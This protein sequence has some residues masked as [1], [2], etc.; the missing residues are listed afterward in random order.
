MSFR[1]RLTLGLVAGAVLPLAGFGLVLLVTG[2]SYRRGLDL[3]AS[4]SS[5]S[6]RR[7]SSPSC[8]R[9]CSPNPDCAA[10]RRLPAVDRARAGDLPCASRCAGEDELAGSS[11]A[12]TGWRA[13]SSGEQELGRILLAIGETSPKDGLDRLVEQATRSARAAFGMIDARIVL[14]DPRWCPPR[15]S[16]RASRARSAPCSRCRRAASASRRAPAGD[17]PLGA[18]D[19]DLLELYATRS[20]SPSATSSCSPRWSTS[21]C[22]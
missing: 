8:S 13:T 15:R 20:P 1:A 21:A 10:A 2:R 22:G 19:Q 4:S 12:T 18:A 11:T 9:P 17:A 3:S 5:C 7:S 6:P 14:G 16:S